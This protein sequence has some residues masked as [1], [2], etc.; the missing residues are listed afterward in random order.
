MSRWRRVLLATTI[1]SAACE[2][3][4]TTNVVPPELVNL[5]ADNLVLGMEH[6]IT[7]NGVRYAT[8]HADTAYYFKDDG[9]YE[10]LSV[11][12]Q[13]FTTTGVE[14]ATMTSEW[15]ELTEATEA[16]VAR[17]NVVLLLPDRDG[18]LE[19]SE[20]NYDPMNE[21]FW[22]DSATV[23]TEAGRVT[24]GTGFEADL[25]FTNIRVRGASIRG[26]GVVRF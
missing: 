21:K 8:L 11:S 16:M 19:T 13:V 5:Q 15:G 6:E 17:R 3:A 23:F 22:S 25:N 18:R 26:R 2:Q 12:L 7:Q 10:L 4:T 9:K 14:R 24:R 1:L 20:L